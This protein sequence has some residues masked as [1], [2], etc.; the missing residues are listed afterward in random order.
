[1]GAEP[2]QHAVPKEFPT[3]LRRYR[4][5]E[6]L[7]GVTGKVA[8]EEREVVHEYRPDDKERATVPVVPVVLWRV[9]MP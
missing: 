3:P 9:Q 2:L 8:E 6:S 1:M 4:P 5:V 7:Q